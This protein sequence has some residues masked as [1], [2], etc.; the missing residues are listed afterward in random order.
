[1]G[2]SKEIEPEILTFW[3]A[4]KI[5]K[6]VVEKNKGKRKFYFLQGPPYTSGRI[7]LAHAWNNSL[8]DIALRYKRMRGYDVWN[9]AGYD[10]HGLP[11]E[12]KVQE[13][14]KLATKKDILTYGVDKFITECIKFASENAT[15][16]VGTV[17]DPDMSEELRVTVVATGLGGESSESPLKI[18]ESKVSDAVH[19]DYRT[20]DRPTVMRKNSQ[21]AVATREVTSTATVEGSKDM[22]YLDIPAFLRRQAD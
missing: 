3:N 22:E 2:Y 17:I 9:R 15:V 21:Q 10:M 8:K 13:A 18:V 6:K 19:P 7:H 11:V 5:Y 12:N 14:L 1:M 4:N 16:V 20:L